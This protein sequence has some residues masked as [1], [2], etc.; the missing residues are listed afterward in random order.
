M[1]A[2]SYVIIVDQISVHM[3]QVHVALTHLTPVET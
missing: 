2:A 1:I 3:V